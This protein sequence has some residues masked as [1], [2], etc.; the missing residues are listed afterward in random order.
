MRRF[1]FLTTADHCSDRECQC[2]L[3][4]QGELFEASPAPP[5]LKLPERPAGRSI[6]FPCRPQGSRQSARGHVHTAALG[7][8]WSPETTAVEQII[9]HQKSG[10]VGN[11]S[12]T[13]AADHPQAGKGKAQEGEAPGLWS[14]DIEVSVTTRVVLNV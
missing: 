6:T 11:S 13:A 12:S 2:A 10:L 7:I 1:H 5:G 14:G 9:Q 8:R 4:L 3:G